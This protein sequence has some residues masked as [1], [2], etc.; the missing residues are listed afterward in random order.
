MNK[1]ISDNPSIN[2]TI[3]FTLKTPDI[4]GCFTE[5]PYKVDKVVIYFIERDFSSGNASTYEEKIYDQEKLKAAIIAETLACSSPTLENIKSA[6]LLRSEAESNFSSTPFHFNDA[7]PINIIGNNLYP[8]WLSTD[9]DN[10]FLDNTD[11][12]EFTYT[13]Q[14]EGMREGDYFICWTW[15]PLI[16]GDNLSDHDK[17]SLTG[18]TQT[19]TSIPSHFTDPKKYT[20]LLE[21]YTPEMFKN[22]ICNNDRT[23]D[24]IDK[25]NQA[26]ALGFNTLEDLANQM[27][28]LQDANS[29][30]EALIPYLSNL[31]GL[32]LKTH[33]PTR[34]RGQIKRAIPL[35]KMKG[36]RKGLA[37]AMEHAS[38]K[39]LKLDQLW[40]IISSY[41]WQETFVYSGNSEFTLEK[42]VETVVEVWLRAIKEDG[43]TY[44]D[45]VQ[46]TT[47]YISVDGTTITWIGDTLEEDAIDLIPKDEI[48]I[49]YL[50]TT[51]EDENLENYIRTLPLMDQRDEISQTYPPK[52]WNVRVIQQDD[53]LFNLIVPNRHPFYDPLIYGQVRTEFPYSENIF[54][55][56]SY[57]G[58]LRDSL[59]PCDIDK[60]FTDPCSACISSSYN[61]ALEIENLSDDRI[62]EAK[63]VLEENTP[64]HSVLHTFNFVGRVNEFLEPQI[65]EI[66]MLVS[67]S[68]E[69]FIIAG[70]AQMYFNR[71]MKL[72]K[73]HGILRNQLASSFVALESTTG[74]AY[75]NEI[76]MFCPSDDLHHLG[77]VNDNTAFI[78]IKSPSPLSGTY[79]VENPQGNTVVISGASEPIDDCNTFFAGDGT[80]NT[81][82]FTFDIN[83]PVP[84]F[85]N[86]L[87]DIEQDNIYRLIDTTQDFTVLGVQTT[88][89]VE[90]SSHTY[91]I[92]DI[93]PDGSL[94]LV[95]DGTLPSSNQSIDYI[96][97][98]NAT[99]VV[100]SSGS[101][102]VTYR[103]KVT[104]LNSATLPVNSYLRLDE[105]FYQKI[106]GIEYL[107]VGFVENT[108]N[109]YYIKNYNNGGAG[110]ITIDMRQK[111]LKN[112]IGYLSHRGLM[113]KISGNLEENLGIQ[114]G[115]NSFVVSDGIE[116]N[117]FKENF[118]V[119]INGENYWISEIDGNNP[120]GYTTITLSGSDH[121]WKTLPEGGTSVNVI[122]YQYLKNGATIMGQQAN[123]P[124]H[125]FSVIDR[126]GR[127]IITGS[128]PED[129]VAVSLSQKEEADD[130]V[131]QKESIS[132]KIE[133]SDGTTE[134]GKI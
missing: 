118:I 75:N 37:E 84:T 115:V 43:I 41:S 132:F 71:A 31:F 52:N 103:G 123:L 125:T 112:K 48:R 81:C 5:N 49:L 23:P 93:L 30:H 32:K 66:E 8:A 58:S 57:N 101:L 36:T 98:N 24:V 130:F 97:Y 83:N 18:D 105:K 14:P 110:G 79:F 54:N 34:W 119:E 116:N 124:E 70:E 109:Q 104:A 95:D 16:A 87:C 20:T 64:F 39:L 85:G 56:E 60:K 78:E 50:H 45:W 13:W 108:N 29:L 26:I 107:I 100:A 17:F 96:I 11:T 22:Y 10:A 129:G 94:V 133:Y 72:I 1:T 4:N 3:V 82:A 80:L 7:K 44:N 127:S 111:I 120:S 12:G 92:N 102:N 53:P 76:L 59:N 33:D 114:N 62:A 2:D 122:I 69:D 55:M 99:V 27:V 51:P 86:T 63:E 42:P 128:T 88:Y 106:D 35:N 134:E 126:S 9:L 67:V 15:T 77:M 68:G 117:G 113:L 19:T 65:E 73:T 21:R 89:T 131:Y 25:F 28:D 90:I 74:T 91:T 47:D 46:L 121:Y 38:I 61:I 6:K 40:Q